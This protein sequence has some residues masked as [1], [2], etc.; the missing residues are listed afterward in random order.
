MLPASFALLQEA[1]GAAHPLAG[2]IARWMWLLPLL[3]LLGFVVNGALSI[4]SAY[5]AGPDDPGAHPHGAHTSPEERHEAHTGHDVTGG[6]AHGDDHH[7]VVR[8]RFAGLTTIIGPGV[9]VLAFALAVAIFVAMKSA[10]N[11]ALHTPF[12]Q[13]YYEWIPVGDLR[14]D[15]AFQ[16]DQLSMMMILV[17]TG[18]GMLI[19]V[20]SVGYM[21][22]DPSYPRYFAYLNLFVAFMLVLVMGASYPVMFVG[23]EGVGLCSYL[24]IGFWYLDKANADA[25][26][27][28]F[29]MNRIGDFGFLVAMFMLYANLGTLEF[30]GVRAQATALAPAVDT[31][32]CLFFFLGCTGKSAQIPLYTWL[33][34]AMAG[35]TPVSALIHAATMV[36]AGVYLIARS[37]FL[38]S[39]SPVASLTVV[40][41]GALTAIFAA[42]IGLKQWD[43]KKV[44]A[45]STVSQLGYMFIGVGSGAYVSGVFHLVT[46]AFFKALLFLGS[47]SVIFAMHRAYHA[48]HSVEDAQDMRNMGGLKRYMPWTFWLM[49]AATLAIA[50]IFPFAGFFSKDAIL[51]TVFLRA[52]ESTLADAHWLGIPGNILLYACYAIGLAAAFMTAVYM[53]RMVIYTFLGPNRSGERERDFLGEAPWIMTGPLL[54][55]GV[56]SVVGG[57]LN[58][59]ESIPIGRVGVLDQWLEPVVGEATLRIT[60]GAAAE[61]SSTIEYSLIGA[62]VLIAVAGI[63]VAWAMLKPERLVPKREA[64]QEEGFERVLANKYYVDEIYD[65]AVV[66]PTVGVSRSLLW[67]GVDQGLIDGVMVTFFGAK[68]PR[69]VGWVGSQ[70]QSGQVGTYAWVL[71]VGVLLVLGAFTIR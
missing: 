12:V 39:L 35:P 26:K 44:L 15:A 31:W 57:W 65:D 27:K 33:P 36:T 53:T 32:I 71:V 64:K 17:I 38:F 59:P 37:N 56:L 8:H 4:V 6:G 20:F 28:A 46:H 21:Q 11:A 45:Y 22:D 63:V 69:F 41:I 16:L 34:D 5:H 18:V 10:G 3:P 2:T 55:L 67:E 68:V 62:A 40:V 29:I 13:R 47:G 30:E 58:L 7:V 66:Q 9:M 23:W 70:L 19:H 42:S 61:A 1:A 24:L 54:V 51:G 25:G 48:T 43:I 60:H 14:I 50:G 49:L 52:R